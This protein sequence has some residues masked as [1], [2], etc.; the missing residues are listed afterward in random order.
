MVL[1]T[2]PESAYRGDEGAI[3]TLFVWSNLLDLESKI[4]I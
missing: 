3:D 1:G 4:W 2:V